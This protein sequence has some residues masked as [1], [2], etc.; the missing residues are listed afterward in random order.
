MKKVIALLL[1][2][3]M[4]ISLIPVTF[5]ED[6]TETTTGVKIE[7]EIG[8]YIKEGGTF[9]DLTYEETDGYWQ[10]AENSKGATV[11][12]ADVDLVEGHGFQYN[13][14]V[15]I[16][17]KIQIPVDGWYRADV[18]YAVFE[19][20][21]GGRPRVCILPSN[22]VLDTYSLTTADLVCT[23]DCRQDTS[24]TLR[25]GWFNSSDE[26]YVATSAQ[27]AK[28]YEAGE[29]YLYFSSHSN[30]GATKKMALGDV[31]LYTVDVSENERGV[32]YDAYTSAYMGIA[33]VEDSTLTVGETTKASA[34]LT[35]SMGGHTEITNFT[36]TSSNEAVAKV[37]A[38]GNVIAVGPGTATISAIA[39]GY[40]GG[41]VIGVDVTVSAPPTTDNNVSFSVAPSE[42][43]A[44]VTVEG[45]DYN[46][47]VESVAR[48]TEVKLTANPL[49]NYTFIGWKRGSNSDDN[50]YISTENPFTTKLYTNTYLTAVYVADTAEEEK[51]VEY[52]N[53]NGDYIS[54]LAPD[55]A[56]PSP[57]VIPGFT[58]AAGNWFIGENMPLVLSEVTKRTRAVAKHT[59]KA[60][61]G[62]VKVNGANDPLTAF[63]SAIKPAAT[64]GFTAWKRDGKVVS[65]NQNYTYYLWDDTTIEQSN[66]A[67]PEGAKLP[68]IILDNDK[69]DGAYMIEYDAADYEIV[70]VGLVFGDGN[71]GTPSVDSCKKKFTSQ[72]K[73][74]HGQMAAKY[75]DNVRGYLIYKDGDNYRV[76]YD[77]IDAQ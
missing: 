35:E 2:I 57:G 6:T 12:C 5:A 41:N 77:G 68:I 1:M 38:D 22:T 30:D 14:D 69:V 33:D 44:T 19:R 47:T 58:F 52:Y 67:L 9:A 70:E 46:E 64:E 4:V 28:H 27:A 25:T 63:D 74:S 51:V 11:D 50:S 36:Y 29:Y 10:Y 32:S 62:T 20:S 17:M 76:I 23:V 65:Y 59:A 42:S 24:A 39:E 66:E 18:K 43:T 75:S 53:Q 56:S 13:G 49:E 31:I 40:A 7:Y 8:D 55:V 72:R 71:D 54:T 34:T 48:G 3:G 45:I 61:A 21:G 37:D 16:A 26:E 73:L 60:N 15:W